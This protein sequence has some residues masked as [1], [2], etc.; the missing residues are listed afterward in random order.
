M[1]IGLPQEEKEQFF[2]LVEWHPSKEF[3]IVAVKNDNEIIELN[4]PELKKQSKDIIVR[5]EEDLKGIR[6]IE[7]CF[8]RECNLLSNR[9]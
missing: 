5:Y 3:V 1:F 6:K 2:K 7:V 9:R 8:P 4:I